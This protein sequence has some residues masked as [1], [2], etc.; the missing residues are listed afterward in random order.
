MFEFNINK[1][2]WLNK[3]REVKISK[4]SLELTTLPNTDLWQKTC[5]M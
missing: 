2:K 4:K 1:L 5:F 3:P